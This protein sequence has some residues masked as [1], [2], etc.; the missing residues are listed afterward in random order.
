MISQLADIFGFCRRRRTILPT[1]QTKK[2]LI[3]FIRESFSPRKKFL[4]NICLKYFLKFVAVPYSLVSGRFIN[5]GD[6]PNG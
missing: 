6:Y 4:G 5:K 2:L 1:P 3:K